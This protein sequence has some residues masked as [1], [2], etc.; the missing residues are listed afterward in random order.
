MYED[1][2]DIM[3]VIATVIYIHHTITVEASRLDL[4]ERELTVSVYV[5]L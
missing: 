5:S 2:L 3:T 4:G 1:T